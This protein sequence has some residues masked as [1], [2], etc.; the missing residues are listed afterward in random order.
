[1]GTGHVAQPGA[2]LRWRSRHGGSIGVGSRAY[3]AETN[4][5]LL[6]CL[7]LR[8]ALTLT[9]S[10]VIG[11]PNG[12]TLGIYPERKIPSSGS[13][14]SLKEKF[15]A[16]GLAQELQV[17]F[18]LVSRCHPPACILVCVEHESSSPFPFFLF[19]FR[20]PWFSRMDLVPLRFSGSRCLLQQDP[21]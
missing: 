7:R 13:K 21:S 15:S 20:R 8:I 17:E 19:P 1:M 16:T 6:F 9:K 10:V 4:L 14:E 5:F 3:T 12:M 2:D 11:V 18:W